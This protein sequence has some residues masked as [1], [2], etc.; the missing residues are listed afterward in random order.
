MA[1]KKVKTPKQFKVEAQFNG[2]KFNKKG[3]DLRK[4]IMS[5]KPEILYT[6]MYITVK[7]GEQVSERRLNLIQG[8]RMFLDDIRLEVFINNL[9]LQ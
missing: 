1:L 5:L 7:K 3:T 2:L 8:K 4:V 9:L 6:E